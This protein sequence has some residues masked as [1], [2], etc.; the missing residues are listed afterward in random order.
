MIRQLSIYSTDNRD[1]YKNLAIEEYL[2]F[3]VN[4]G[5]CIL[6]LWQN[7][8][9]VVIG[10]NQNCWKECRVHELETE[11]GC[12]VRRLSG[13]GAVFHDLGNLNFTFCVRKEDYDVDRQT[14]VVLE[15]VRLL[16]IRAEK[17][18]R[19]DLTAEGR[20]FSGNAFYQSGDFCCH[21]G[22]LLICGDRQRMGKYLCVSREKLQSKGVASVRGRTVNL[23]E[24]KPDLTVEAA[25]LA[26]AEAFEIVYG[27]GR[28]TRA[29]ERP[30]PGKRQTDPIN[31]EQQKLQ[32]NKKEPAGNRKRLKFLDEERLDWQEIG[33]L[34]KRF[35]SWEW[36]YGKNLSFQH[37]M[38]RRFPWGEAELQFQVKEGRVLEAAVFSDGMDADFFSRLP[39]VWRDC[40]YEAEALV[41]AMEQAVGE[42]QAAGQKQMAGAAGISKDLAELIQENL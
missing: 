22:T 3:H 20:K 42:P 33:A 12:L 29:K 16:G 2:T 34:E 36:R 4:K 19:N 40:P 23:Q 32:E 17:N 27:S 14:E 21:H 38:R 7:Q 35:S 10:K 11:G 24:I 41:Q 8:N 15:A 37:Q 18:G 25:K 9:C 6:F 28:Q 5:E 1:P 26:M 31:E 13:G 30:E 39:E